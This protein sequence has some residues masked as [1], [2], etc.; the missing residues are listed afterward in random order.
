M[1]LLD[2]DGTTMACADLFHSSTA[3]GGSFSSCILI[4]EAFLN[5]PSPS[6]A[7]CTFGWTAL[8]VHKPCPTSLI[9]TCISMCADQHLCSTDSL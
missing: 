4:A 3:L 6:P 2:I 1:G 8:K 9:Y 7:K 5:K